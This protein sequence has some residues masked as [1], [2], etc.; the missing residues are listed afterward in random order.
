MFRHVG[1]CCTSA[2]KLKVKLFTQGQKDAG[3][4]RDGCQAATAP[5]GVAISRPRSQVSCIGPLRTED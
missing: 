5:A 4:M 3:T 2:N 1:S